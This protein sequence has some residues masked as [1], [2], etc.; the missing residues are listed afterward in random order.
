MKIKQEIE[1]YCKLNGINDVESIIN[2]CL[3][4]GF[5]I[6]KYGV[7]PQ[8]NFR[9]ENK[10]SKEPVSEINHSSNKEDDKVNDN[11]ISTM[12]ELNG[13]ENHKKKIKII[14]K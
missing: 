13:V 14:K 8:D 11:S 9:K 5:N 6:M 4:I 3:R 10:I 2:E 1:N 12:E 7:S